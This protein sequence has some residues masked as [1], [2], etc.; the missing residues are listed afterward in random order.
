MIMTIVMSAKMMMSTLMKITVM[1][2]LKT[3][4]ITAVTQMIIM[5]LV[6]KMKMQ[7]SITM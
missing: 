7:M 6:I 1:R 5:R 3:A 2:P 4:T